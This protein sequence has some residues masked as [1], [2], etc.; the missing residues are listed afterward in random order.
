MLLQFAGTTNVR[1][2]NVTRPPLPGMFQISVER[3]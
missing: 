1:F 3:S 2:P